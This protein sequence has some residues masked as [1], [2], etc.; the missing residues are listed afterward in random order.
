MTVADRLDQ[1]L[2]IAGAISR[3]E[4]PPYQHNECF[5]AGAYDL[6]LI[7]AR[8]A[9]A[10]DLLQALCDRYDSVRASG[11]LPGYFYLIAQLVHQSDTTEMPHGLEAIMAAHPELT[12]QIGTWYRRAG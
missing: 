8:G 1:L 7:K 10:F 6:L 5:T 12:R 9:E 3:G 11:E 2:T 4:V